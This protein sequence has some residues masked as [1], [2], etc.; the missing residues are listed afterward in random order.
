MIWQVAPLSTSHLLLGSPPPIEWTFSRDWF[1]LHDASHQQL[2]QC[3]SLRLP[4]QKSWTS[5]EYTWSSDWYGWPNHLDLHVQALGFHPHH[6]LPVH[7]HLH[8]HDHALHLLPHHQQFET[9]LLF[10]GPSLFYLLFLHHVHQTDLSCHFHPFLWNWMTGT[11]VSVWVSC[12]DASPNSFFPND[13]SFHN[14]CTSWVPD[15]SQLKQV[16]SFKS[17]FCIVCWVF[18]CCFVVCLVLLGFIGVWFLLFF[19]PIRMR[20]FSHRSCEIRHF[21]SS[22]RGH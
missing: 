19:S 9:C 18:A 13:P 21:V 2:S 10:H 11:L 17:A 5:H 20:V 1:H 15:N 14:D 3:S 16:L 22:E 7:S 4:Q 12:L 8:S 6:T